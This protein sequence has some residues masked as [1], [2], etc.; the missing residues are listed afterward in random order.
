LPTHDTREGYSLDLGGRGAEMRELVVGD[1]IGGRDPRGKSGESG[2][3]RVLSG[4]RELPS[5]RMSISGLED[6]VGF[7][8]RGAG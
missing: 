8:T 4:G 1:D 2:V 5:T 7:G 3:G 6:V